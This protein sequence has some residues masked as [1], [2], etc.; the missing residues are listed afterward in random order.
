MSPSHAK[1][2]L[3]VFGLI[4][5]VL[6]ALMLCVTPFIF[7]KVYSDMSSMV[8]LLGLFPFC[9]AAYFIY[10]AYLVW[11]NFSP[12]AICHSCSTAGVFILVL[13]SNFMS[14]STKPNS[15]E[16]IPWEDVAFL[17]SIVVVYFGYKIAS[18]YL[19]NILFPKT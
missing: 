7:S 9:V 6:G 2:A 1:I 15:T 19:I 10:A 8:I 12:Q 14:S 18:R 13:A 3:K 5:G 16:S 17:V 4:V 11:F